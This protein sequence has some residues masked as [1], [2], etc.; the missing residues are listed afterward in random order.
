MSFLL[1]ALMLSSWS[2]M[3]YLTINSSIKFP[4]EYTKTNPD[5]MMLDSLLMETLLKLNF[6]GKR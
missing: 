1:L 6:K 2:G 3:Y 5:Y 4:N